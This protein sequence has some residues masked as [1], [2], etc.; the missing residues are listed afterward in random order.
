MAKRVL[1]LVGVSLAVLFQFFWKLDNADAQGSS[2]NSTP[3]TNLII[4]IAQTVTN[5][6]FGPVWQNV[7]TIYGTNGSVAVFAQTN[8][9]IRTFWAPF[10][11]V[12]T[13]DATDS[14][15][16]T[17]STTF[18]SEVV[19]NPP[20]CGDPYNLDSDNDGLPD[21]VENMLNTDPNNPDSDGDGYTDLQEV[22]LGTDP[23][24]A[25]SYPP[26]PPFLAAWWTFDDTNGT[27]VT[28]ASGNL[29]TGVLEGTPN[30]TPVTN[31]VADGALSFDGSNSFLVTPATAMFCNLSTQLTVSA[32]INPLNQFFHGGPPIAKW[33]GY[34]DAQFGTSINHDACGFTLEFHDPTNVWFLVY[35]S[36]LGTWIGTPLAHVSTNQWTHIV[37]IYDGSAVHIYTN[38][39]LAG[40]TT[41]NIGN[42][43][44]CGT[45]LS[46]ANDL[47]N[48]DRFYH[49]LIDDVRIYYTALGTADVYA[50]YKMDTDHDGLA[51]IDEINIYGTNPNLFD[52]DGDGY[53]DRQRMALGS[54]PTNSAGYVPPYLLGWWKFLDGS[55]SLDADSS[56]NAVGGEV[57]GSSTWLSTGVF[58]G[59]LQF[60][61]STTYVT[62]PATTL[63]VLTTQLTV[64][65]WIN[66]PGQ[67]SGSA[68]P[69]TKWNECMTGG[70]IGGFTME[71]SGSTNVLFYLYS[72]SAQN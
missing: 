34:E 45:D 1:V 15:S 21:S 44:T 24:V 46:I 8:T 25:C 26:I 65:V 30:P 53:G 4:E 61:G 6:D 36:D 11:N 7:W 18:Y 9:S 10:S 69:L 56:S 33:N 71:F 20:Y 62:N 23:L 35:S 43:T 68:S 19:S 55:G 40:S 39:A 67:G 2:T 13:G 37:G 59:A 27:L 54:N 57:V 63:G 12:T 32:W 47:V 31:G 48:A 72:T 49:G 66:A 60:D 5:N 52:S 17:E 29:Q 50:V 14:V 58:G 22:V 64:A 41:T 42:I 51:N 28:D 3:Y 70:D 38:G 16:T